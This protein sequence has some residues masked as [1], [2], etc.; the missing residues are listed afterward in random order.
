MSNEVLDDVVRILNIWDS[1][2]A[3]S[4]EITGRLLAAFDDCYPDFARGTDDEA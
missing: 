4:L 2:I 1:L 3:E